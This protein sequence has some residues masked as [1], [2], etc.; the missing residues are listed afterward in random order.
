MRQSR[1]CTLK[2]ESKVVLSL[3]KI[4]QRIEQNPRAEFL[5]DPE[6]R[7][8]YRD[9]SEMTQRLVAHFDEL[10]LSDGD[11]I[12][13]ATRNEFLACSTFIAA[14][15]DGLVPVMLSPD[16]PP[17]RVASTAGS[18]SAR[19]IVADSEASWM[20]ELGLQCVAPRIREEVKGWKHL[21]ANRQP[22]SWLAD[23][24][25]LSDDS[26]APRLPD[27]IDELA[28][29]G[30][31]SGTTSSPTGVMISRRNIL[32][33]LT[34]LARLFDCDA[35]TRLFN[36]MILAHA[37]GL[38]QGPL[39]AIACGGC[40][41]R[42]GGFR[43]DR[44]EAWLN[45]VR[46]ERA[47]HVITVPT[48]WSLIDRY[49]EHDDYFDSPECQ[50]LMSVAS[51][52]DPKLWQ[53]LEE[54][55]KRP[56]FNQYG[57]TETVASVLYAGPH[58]EMGAFDS[59][60]KPVDC[61]ARLAA[62]SVESGIGELQIRGDN[63][64]VG[65][66]QNSER[67]RQLFTDD[68]WMRT[69]D[70][71]EQCDDGSYRICG[72]V[73]TII[74]C[75]GVLIRPEEIDEVMVAHPAVV[76]S[77]TIGMADDT[78]E[79]APVTAVVLD[80]PADEASLTAHA[81][82]GLEPLKVP[83]RIVILP[84]IPRGDAGKPNFARLRTVIADAIENSIS[85]DAI[86]DGTLGSTIAENTAAAVLKV[87]SKVFRVDSAEIRANSTP[88]DIPG[89]DSFSHIALIL[90]IEERFKF[91]IPVSRAT[92]LRSMGKVVS[93]VEEMAP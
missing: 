57:L 64:F 75:G 88:D 19:A 65:Y 9:L 54:R 27:E 25:G 89:W 24:L 59:I 67:T 56:M 84:A 18:V 38:V 43:V 66:W 1:R 16:S 10:N 11:R 49:A 26:R 4:W 63:V 81:R 20:S 58:P 3:K 91:R 70:L 76:E 35:N 37:D 42:S 79:E 80:A 22:G 93:V 82:A 13:I 21:F 40:V 71:A 23:S 74:N 52:L 77:A 61:E 6:A 17:A 36:D 87:A 62:D 53:R 33:N 2:M 46:R 85:D 72:R 68:G 92:G 39:L 90:A 48:V 60:G 34:T 41:I 5:V 45:R 69:G 32:A 47:T 51:R 83:K 44:I 7:F 12:L 31:T 73:K 15:L 86:A 50:R 28:Y 14:M 30:F 55:F 78:F 29:L 8:Q